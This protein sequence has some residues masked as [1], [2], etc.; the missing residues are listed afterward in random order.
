MTGSLLLELVAILALV[1][2][3]GL[4]ALAEFSIIAS[5][6]SR[7]RQKAQ[8]GKPGA[9]AAEKLHR[10]P[11]KFLATIQVGITLF[12]TLAGVFGGATI[13]SHL[14]KLLNK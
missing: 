6:I 7:L 11:E 12:S 14:Q 8:Q 1:L 9:A 13:V 10:N 4:F 3:N 5:R 2:A